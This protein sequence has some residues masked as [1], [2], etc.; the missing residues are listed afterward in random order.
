MKH[1]LLLTSVIALQAFA[2]D[3]LQ[4]PTELLYWNPAR[5][6]NGYTFFGVGGTTYLIDMEGRVAHT[7]PLGNNPHLQDDGSVL[8]TSS[9]DP[10]GFAGFRLVD[11]DGRIAWQYTERRS[12][13]HPHHDFIRMYNPKLKAYTVVYIA[14]RDYTAAECIAACANP[15]RVPASGAQMDTLVEV[16]AS[17]TVVW[18]WRFFDHLVQD[19]DPAKPNYVGA[20]KTIA[21]YPGRL[22]I[23]LAGHPLKGDWLHLNS[24]RRVFTGSNVDDIRISLTLR[25]P[26]P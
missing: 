17:G 23:N 14:N 11:W 26:L 8:D 24:V 12:N 5:A 4:G 15:Q 18:E 3:A 21:D 10:S 6:Q 9:N 13:Y 1:A 7:W 20:A 25:A 22:N 16:D 19:L 2:Y